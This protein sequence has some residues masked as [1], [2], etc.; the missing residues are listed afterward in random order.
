MKRARE[1]DPDLIIL[2]GFH[3]ATEP[4]L[5]PP[6]RRP[7]A[8]ESPSTAPGRD[9]ERR[10]KRSGEGAEARSGRSG[11][12][13]W[14]SRRKISMLADAEKLMSTAPLMVPAARYGASGASAVSAARCAL[15]MHAIAGETAQIWARPRSRA[16]PG[17]GRCVARRNCGGDLE[18]GERRREVVVRRERVGDFSLGRI[19]A[20]LIGGVCVC[21][22][23]WHA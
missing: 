5:R 16:R 2:S 4:S 19:G 1:A 11:E 3:T 7:S 9:Q 22:A 14:K 15:L 17:Q 8:K 21:P 18:G 20:D 23:C 13:D 10:L 6:A 12:S